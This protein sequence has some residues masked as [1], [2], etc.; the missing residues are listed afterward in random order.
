MRGLK[1]VVLTRDSERF[2]GALTIAAA[3]AAI[4]GEAAVMLQLDAVALLHRPI[5]AHDDVACAAIGLPTLGELIEEALDLG[6]EFVACQT[7]LVLAA[8]PAAEL[9]PRIAVGGPVGFM[10]ALSDSDRLVLV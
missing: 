2:R 1:I 8:L 7:G 4:G 6:V 3:H 9:D 10:Q 5:R